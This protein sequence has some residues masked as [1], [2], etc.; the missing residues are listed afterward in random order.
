MLT[1]EQWER[2]GVCEVTKPNTH[3]EGDLTNTVYDE[4]MGVLE[5]G[6][7]C[8]TCAYDASICPG[9]FGYIKLA[10]PVFNI[11]YLPIVQSIVKCIC[12]EC[13]TLRVSPEY[14]ELR[15]I[16][17]I[18]SDRR[19]KALL[20]LCKQAKTC[21]RC[22]KTLPTGLDKEGIRCLYRDANGQRT[23]PKTAADILT[24]F[25]EVGPVAFALMGF[26]QNLAPNPFFKTEVALTGD[27]TYVE[28]IHQNSPRALIFTVLPVTPPFARPWVIRNGD[29]SD[30]D[31]TEKY[32]NIVKTNQRIRERELTEVAREDAIRKLE[33]HINTLI[34]NHAESSKG[35]ARTHRGL[36]D[37]IQGKGNRMQENVMAKRTDF[38]ARTVLAGAGPEARFGQIG[39]PRR[40]AETL[41]VKARVT[42]MNYQHICE[43]MEKGKI[44]SLWRWDKLQKKHRYKGLATAEIKKNVGIR[45]GDI[46]ERHLKEGDWV[47]LNRQPTL[48]KESMVGCQVAIIEDDVFR[49]PLA[50]TTPLG[51]DFDGPTN[52]GRTSK[53]TKSEVKFA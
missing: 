47:L 23:I 41:T 6:K 7:E 36:C 52:N 44:N 42:R 18:A 30:D 25:E 27:E 17:K 35:S 14:A 38:S 46:I 32:N 9:H 1:G 26:N 2:Y 43:Q 22:G 16:Q 48:R 10:V 45:V 13:G 50:I 31:L 5:V 24:L 12:V 15:G 49:I 11:K 28:H 51:A 20:K 8:L 53:Q 33:E 4:R 3:G 29:K 37:R 21:R 40:M 19:L 34:D 39:V